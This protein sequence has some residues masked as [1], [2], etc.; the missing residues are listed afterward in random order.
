M[1]ELMF[2]VTGHDR[3]WHNCGGL[4]DALTVAT[5]EWATAA[6]GVALA[7]LAVA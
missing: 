1:L 5:A 7:V 4:N 6:D 2:F 3:I